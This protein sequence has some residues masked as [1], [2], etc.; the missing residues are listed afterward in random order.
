MS[1]PFTPLLQPLLATT[2]PNPLGPVDPVPEPEPGQPLQPEPLGPQPTP[3][4]T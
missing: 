4:P 2:H 3:A 1:T